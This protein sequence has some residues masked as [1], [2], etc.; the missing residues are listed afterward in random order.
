MNVTFPTLME[1]FSV[2]IATVQWI[3]TG[4]LLLLLPLLLL[5]LVFGV[6]SIRQV[7][8]SERMPFPWLEYLL[9]ACAFVCFIFA[10]TGAASAGRLGAHTLGLFAAAAV[11]AAAFCFHCKGA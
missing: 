11:C 7:S 6:T 2:T 5:S 8:E 1:E 10:L 9:L 3:T 4:Y